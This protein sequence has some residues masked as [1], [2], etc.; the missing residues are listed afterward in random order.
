MAQMMLGRYFGGLQGAQASNGSG[1]TQTRR[2][3]EGN[4]SGR[5]LQTRPL[6]I[7]GI[8]IRD[9]GS[10]VARNAKGNSLTWENLDLMKIEEVVL[11][12]KDGLPVDGHCPRRG[13]AIFC[14]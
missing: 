7:H 9:W 14:P 4:Y 10:R 12:F 5:R 1:W 2:S 8:R 13:W 11:H 3:N 6:L